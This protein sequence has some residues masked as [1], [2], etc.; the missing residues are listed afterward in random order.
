MSA[1]AVMYAALFTAG[2]QALAIYSTQAPAGG[3]AWA[4]Q[5]ALAAAAPAAARAQARVLAPSI[6]SLRLHAAELAHG[7]Q[8]VPKP[9][10]AA[11]V[12][13]ASATETLSNSRPQYDPMPRLYLMVHQH[14]II[15]R[16]RMVR[17]HHMIRQQ[18]YASMSNNPGNY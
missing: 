13:M 7:A 4:A 16:D 10:N 6:V 12:A 17:Q 8:D 14:K 1:R 5:T 18:L 3:R 15:H 2:V 9:A 11:T